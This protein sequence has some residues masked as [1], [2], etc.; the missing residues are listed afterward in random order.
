VKITSKGLQK[1]RMVDAWKTYLRIL[2]DKHARAGVTN[3]T[4]RNF[5]TSVY[6]YRQKRLGLRHV[7]LKRILEKNAIDSRPLE[8]ECP[9]PMVL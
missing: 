5:K 2:T 8:I 1:K 4:F 7:Y 9:R 3:M 6:T